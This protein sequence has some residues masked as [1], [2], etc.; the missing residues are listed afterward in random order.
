MPAILRILLPNLYPLT[1]IIR[2]YAVY[3]RVGVR[4]AGSA[5]LV[6]GSN[7]IGVCNIIPFRGCGY[8]GVAVAFGPVVN[9]ILSNSVWFVWFDRGGW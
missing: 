4:T 8:A 3:D 7:D 1:A 9:P 5:T 2:P 6:Y